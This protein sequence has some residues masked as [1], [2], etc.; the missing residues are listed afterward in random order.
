MSRIVRDME[1]AT[2]PN[3]SVFLAEDTPAIR[4]RLTQMLKKIDGVRI[5]GEADSPSSAIEGILRTS[6]HIVVLDIHLIGGTGLDVLRKLK[7]SHPEIVFIVL[8]N[9]TAPQYRNAYMSNGA[10]YFLDKSNEFEKVRD[11]ISGIVTPP[12]VEP[13]TNQANS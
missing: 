6:P 2:A 4:S 12:A 8:T 10:S 3:C 7:P 5:A 11:L 9:H 13:D 1:N